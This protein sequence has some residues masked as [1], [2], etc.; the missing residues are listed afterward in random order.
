MARGVH[1]IGREAEVAMLEDRVRRCASGEGGVLL[2]SG[3]AGVGKTSLVTGVAERFDGRVVHARAMRGAPAY[4]PL[5][6]FAPTEPVEGPQ[7]ATAILDGLLAESRREPCLAH[8]ED[9]QD[10]DAAT[11]ELLARA[12]EILADRPLLVIVEY[13][14]DQLPRQHPVRTLRAELRRRR[15]PVGIVLEPFTADQTR[16]LAEAVTGGPVEDALVDV[17]H[18]RSDGNPFFAEELLRAHLDARE[19]DTTPRQDAPLPD[20]LLDAVLARTETLRAEHPDAVRYAAVLGTQVELA[21]LEALTDPLAVDALLDD[22]LLVE[23]DEEVAAFRHGLVREALV[24]ATPWAQRRRIHREV[25]ELL[26]RRSS[27]PS[28]VAEHWAAAHEPDRARHLF[29]RALEQYCA[30]EALRDATVAA[31]RA[32]ELWPAGVDP[33]GRVRTQEQLADCCEAHGDFQ[34]ASSTWREVADHHRVAG[35]TARAA[36]AHRR[37]ATAAEMLGDVDATL[38][39]RHLAAEAY[40]TADDPGSAAEERLA[41]AQ[42]LKAAG[43]LSRALDEAEAAGRLATTAGKRTVALTAMALEGATRSALGEGA[44]GVALARA[45]VAEAMTAQLAGASA[46]AV[47]ELGEALEYASDYVAALETYQQA[48]DLC[49]GHDLAELQTV[50]YVCTSPVAR[51]MGEWDRVL[52]VCDRVRGDEDVQV[53]VRR[54]A[55]EEAGLVAALRGDVRR[56]RSALRRA[57]DFGQAYAVFGIEIGAVWGLA[58]LAA[59]EGHQQTTRQ[60]VDRLLVLCAASDESHYSLPA[61]RWAAT[62]VAGVGSPEEVAEVH[63]AATRRSRDNTAPKVLSTVAHCGAELAAADG[64][65]DRA[66]VLMTRAVDLIA[67]MRSPYESALSTHCLGRIEAALGRRRE[68][69]HHLTSAHHTARLLGARP[70]ARACAEELA[71]LGEPVD[72]R[73]GRRAARELADHGLTRRELEVLRHLALGQTNREIAAALFL[74]VRTVDMHVRHILEKL[75]CSSR[76]AAVRE[77]VRRELVP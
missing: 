58:Q 65:L 72:R 73:L 68:A 77:A 5:T 13:R 26:E 40:E 46:E 9:C 12:D 62:W 11:L 24:R 60:L 2:L 39:H 63:R 71:A 36:H 54:V 29:L 75:G 20:T 21:V 3:E 7:L 74:S 38:Q 59:L 57:A 48:V 70:L 6:A 61:L 76:V 64:D 22:G 44:R 15:D 52:E 18:R 14:S 35:S 47:Y 34:L 33:D 50:C 27:P 31:R 8:L 67:E 1:L 23:F 51:L 4:A 53:F 45:A 28:V 43:L 55:D 56:A 69:I 10:A 37:A 42:R 66:A 19:A 17:V 41:L 25:A 30:A 49:A 32:L 16:A